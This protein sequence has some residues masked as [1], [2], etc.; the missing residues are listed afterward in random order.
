MLN[1]EKPPQPSTQRV[2]TANSEHS[3]SHAAFDSLRQEIQSPSLSR[4]RA[5]QILAHCIAERLMAENVR[6]RL[7]KDLTSEQISMLID[8]LGEKF[9]TNSFKAESKSDPKSSAFPLS[10][11]VRVNQNMTTHGLDGVGKIERSPK[12]AVSKFSL[13]IPTPEPHGFPYPS[14]PPLASHAGS[15]SREA[16]RGSALTTLPGPQ[17]TCVKIGSSAS[18][19]F[20][21]P[22]VQ[23]LAP[24]RPPRTQMEQA[25]ANKL[26]CMHPAVTDEEIAQFAA[27]LRRVEQR[28]GIAN[29][30]LDM[31]RWALY[32]LDTRLQQAPSKSPQKAAVQGQPLS[33]HQTQVQQTPFPSTASQPTEKPVPPPSRPPTADSSPRVLPLILPSQRLEP[34]RTGAVPRSDRQLNTESY[35]PLLAPHNAALQALKD[36][37]HKAGGLS[38]H[39]RRPSLR[40]ETACQFLDARREDMK[41]PDGPPEQQFAGMDR[42][43][44]LRIADRLEKGLTSDQ[45]ANASNGGYALHGQGQYYMQT[46]AN[47][48]ARSDFLMD[49][50]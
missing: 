50:R 21:S 16:R 20:L 29:M 15:S 30:G 32:V 49:C 26:S 18:S 8:M 23:P 31:V 28:N 5:Q 39:N 37:V 10:E 43:G 13:S 22:P 1:S 4:G 11:S 14:Q 19:S 33:P 46:Y 34:P 6:R 48:R 12:L 24:P 35:K 47:V 42:H 36:R 25:L 27:L 3:D 17:S 9:K 45:C 2:T 41:Y 7:R 38:N 40:Y 44:L